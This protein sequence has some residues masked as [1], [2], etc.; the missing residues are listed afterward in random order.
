M[1]SSTAPYDQV[2]K[3][4]VDYMMMDYLA[5]VTMS[6]MQK[7]RRKDPILGY[8]R[9]LIP[10]MERILPVIAKKN[11][12]VITNGGGVNSHCLQGRN[13]PGCREARHQR[14]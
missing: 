3:G 5:E 4:P 2:T 14:V 9:D 6:I 8:A 11:I 13:F 7:Q 12:R 10:L 1:I